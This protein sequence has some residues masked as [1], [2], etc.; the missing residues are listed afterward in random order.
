[1]QSSGAL[2]Y[3]QA[4]AKREAD[5]ALACIKDFPANEATSALHALCEY[6]LARQT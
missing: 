4:A 2:D 1:V 5:L 3:T 6:S